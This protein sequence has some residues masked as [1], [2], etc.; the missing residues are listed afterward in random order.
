MRITQESRRL[1]CGF[2]WQ[3]RERNAVHHDTVAAMQ[4]AARVEHGSSADYAS[5]LNRRV[6]QR[7]HFCGASESQALREVQ[8]AGLRAY[9]RQ[10]QTH[11]ITQDAHSAPNA[12]R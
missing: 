8:G 1:C 5:G 2:W 11:A 10:L 3:E 7:T 4:D 12:S 6:Q 9:K